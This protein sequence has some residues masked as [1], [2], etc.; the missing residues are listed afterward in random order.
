MRLKATLRDLRRLLVPHA[1]QGKW[2]LK[3]W[4]LYATMRNIMETLCDLLGNLTQRRVILGPIGDLR[5]FKENKPKNHDDFVRFRATNSNFVRL[6][7]QLV[8]VAYS[9]FS[10]LYANQSESRTIHLKFMATIVT[11]DPCVGLSISLPNVRLIWLV[12]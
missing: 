5:R 10:E 8:C 1:I 3:S 2:S 7:R 12:T 9:D 4:R 6:L 11:L